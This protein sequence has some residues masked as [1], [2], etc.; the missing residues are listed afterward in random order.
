[1]DGTQVGVS[2]SGDILDISIGSSNPPRGPAG[3]GA[4][5]PAFRQRMAGA[6]TERPQ[7]KEAA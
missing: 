4:G 5:S 3:Y 7:P 2:A 6:H 1:L